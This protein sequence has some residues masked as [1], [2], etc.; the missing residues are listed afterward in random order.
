MNAINTKQKKQITIWERLALGGLVLILLA[1]LAGLT[2][3]ASVPPEQRI[4]RMATLAEL[5]A[6]T[7][8]SVDLT[9]HPDHKVY[10]EASLAALDGLLQSAN[11]DPTAFARALQQLPVKE[12]RGDTGAI[13]VNSAVIL[14][15]EYAAEVVNLDTTQYV[16]PVIVS[17]RNGL[18]RSLGKEVQ[19]FGLK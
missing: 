12:L 9:A 16:R 13:V 8:S 3:C 19:T 4:A 1:I 11:Y 17:V 14:W 2:G 7:G 18:A 6:Y 10:Y 15:H 5:A